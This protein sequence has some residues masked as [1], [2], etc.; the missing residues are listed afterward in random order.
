S[1]TSLSGI[2]DF[3]V[4]RLNVDGSPDLSFGLDGKITTD[5]FGATDAGTAL[6]LQSNGRIVV[7]GFAFK[8]V[9]LLGGDFALARY[10]GDAPVF[11]IC[12]QD[13]SN[14]NLLQF[15]SITGDFQFTNCGGLTLGGT[16]V[17]TTRGSTTILQG[18]GPDRRI[19]AKF[20][21]GANRGT[22]SIQVLSSGARFTITD[23]NT[24]NNT[25][26]CATTTKGV[27]GS[28]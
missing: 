13:D 27:G 4:A 19:L 9:G 14:G 18:N 8:S 28:R 5:F 12:L 24:L 22:A 2:E 3:A 6:A 25:C 1:T 23:R 16:G 26:A 11:D 21:G 7:A 10:D 17:V 15:D 20:V